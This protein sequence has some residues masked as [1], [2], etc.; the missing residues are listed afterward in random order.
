MK[1]MN[2]QSEETSANHHLK[3]LGEKIATNL[4]GVNQSVKSQVNSRLNVIID[5]SKGTM[6]VEQGK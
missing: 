1:N 6:V 3:A 4:H 5:W 2:P